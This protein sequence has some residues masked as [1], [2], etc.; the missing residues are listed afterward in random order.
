[1]AAITL[2]EYAKGEE[3]QLRRG[4]IEIFSEGPLLGL[5]PIDT[6]PGGGYFYNTEASLPSV[7]FRAINEGYTA[8]AG[9]INNQSEALKIVGGDLD[10]DLFL[11]RQ[12]GPEKRGQQVAMKTKALRMAV[13]AKLNKADTLSDPRQFDGLQVRIPAG[14]T[15]YVDAGQNGAALS[16]GML[17]DLIDRVDATDAPRILVCNRTIGRLLTAAQR[18]SS[19]SGFI[20]NTPDSLGRT[21]TR[22]NGIPLVF[23]DMDNTGAQILPFSETKGSSN[24][25]TSIYCLQPGDGFFHLIQGLGGVDV[26]DLGEID[27]ASVARTR[28]DWSLGMVIEHGRSVARLAG[29]TNSAVVA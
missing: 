25:T 24:A 1:M 26:R 16:L 18:N 7:Q 10:V 12:Y 14:T 2:A 27:T 4:I 13:E 11:I 21:V 15:Q 29:I 9:V 22:Y 3:G 23:L 8:D 19:V 20:S 28:I 5:M 17:D 6:I